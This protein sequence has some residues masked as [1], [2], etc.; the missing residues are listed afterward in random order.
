MT[1]FSFP[2]HPTLSCVLFSFSVCS[3]ETLYYKGQPKARIFTTKRKG[4]WTTFIKQGKK[5]IYK[6]GHTHPM[7]VIFYR[8][9]GLILAEENA[10]G[11]EVGSLHSCRQAWV[12]QLSSTAISQPLPKIWIPPFNTRHFT[13]NLHCHSSGNRD[14]NYTLA[15][16]TQGLRGAAYKRNI[17]PPGSFLL[18]G[19]CACECKLI[20]WENDGDSGVLQLQ[21]L[22]KQTPAMG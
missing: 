21:V 12:M 2:A 22:C 10:K 14:T 11:W 4:R 8:P 19:L 3:K 16:H 15:F 5:K 18:G 9:L 13:W 7:L 20:R 6:S 17:S 1:L